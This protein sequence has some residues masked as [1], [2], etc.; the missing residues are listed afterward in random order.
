[1]KP[2]NDYN[3]Y[4][5]AKYGCRVYRI[6]IDAGFTCPNRDG[7]MGTLGCIYCNENGSRAPYANPKETVSRQIASRIEYLR[8]KKGARKFIAYFQAFSNTYAP[9][10]KLKAVYDE[11]LPFKDIVGISI[12]TRPDTVDREKARLIAGYRDRYEVWLEYGLQSA[13]DRTLE[14][15]NRKHDFDN[16]VKA[17]ALARE[18]DIMVSAHVILGL[19]GETKA[20]MIETAKKL[21]G[22]KINGV[23]IHLLH[24]LKGS[25][26]ERLYS[27]GKVMLLEEDEYCGLVSE[28]LRNLAPD[29]IIQRLTAQGKAEEHVAPSWALDKTRTLKKIEEAISSNRPR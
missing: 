1:M 9:V 6:G 15:I 27:E 19:P 23:K 12:G 11:V 20:D 28:F 22:L 26:L 13:H 18:F 21:T 3:S 8:Q 17:V 29:I 5:R 4:L 25:A 2:Y 14:L 7:T 10:Q 24:V 16:F